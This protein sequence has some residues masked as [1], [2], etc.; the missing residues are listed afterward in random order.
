VLHVMGVPAP[1]ADS[2]AFVLVVAAATTIVIV[3]FI[4]PGAKAFVGVQTDLFI[5]FLLSLTAQFAA[6]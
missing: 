1:P 4:S 3:S 2:S 6:A 5:N